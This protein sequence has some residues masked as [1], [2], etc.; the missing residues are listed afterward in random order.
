MKQMRFLVLLLL[1]LTVSLTAYSQ[2]SGLSREQK[3]EIVSALESYDAVVIE[4]DLTQQLLSQCNEINLL[5]KAQLSTKDEIIRNLEEQIKTFEKE[6][7]VQNS[8]IRK[9]K[10]KGFITMAGGAGLL[11]LSLILK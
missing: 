4:I 11:I 7:D 9:Q 5:L 6:V 2:I 10:R 3:V 1:T 8:E